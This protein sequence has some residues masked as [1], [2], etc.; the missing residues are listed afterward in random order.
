MLYL[1]IHFYNI[2]YIIY[3]DV[4]LKIV[5][6][7]EDALVWQLKWEDIFLLNNIGKWP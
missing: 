3:R 4:S 2:V 5:Q 1:F 7:K 6:L